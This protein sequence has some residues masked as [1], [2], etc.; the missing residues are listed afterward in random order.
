MLSGPTGYFIRLVVIGAIAFTTAW[1]AQSQ[2]TK[3]P[4]KSLRQIG[5]PRSV[6]HGAI[7]I[8]RESIPATTSEVFP[9][10]AQSRWAKEN[11]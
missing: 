1:V 7:R 2:T 9:L 6:H 4:V 11:S 10:N 3:T 5:Q 8:Y